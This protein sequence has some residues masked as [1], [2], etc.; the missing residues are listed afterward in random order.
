MTA[1][2]GMWHIFRNHIIPAARTVQLVLTNMRL[3]FPKLRTGELTPESRR[4]MLCVPQLHTQRT[5]TEFVHF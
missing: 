5:G 4:K 2:G 1:K 3:Y